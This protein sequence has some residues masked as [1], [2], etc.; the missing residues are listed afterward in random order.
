MRDRHW[1]KVKNTIGR[2]FDESSDNFTLDAVADMQMQN[3]ADQISDVSNAATMEL[4]I[5]TVLYTMDIE[6]YSPYS[7]FAYVTGRDI[8]CSL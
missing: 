6:E 4:A 8:I 3:F 1:R 7:L 5:E 2:E